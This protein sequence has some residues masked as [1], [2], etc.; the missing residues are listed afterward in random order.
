MNWS[1][2]IGFE[3]LYEVS[4]DGQVRSLTYPTSGGRRPR[5]SPLLIKQR[6]LRGDQYLSASL[7]DSAGKSH[8]KYVHSLVAEAFIGARPAGMDCRHADG[9][10]SNNALTNL[11]WRPESRLSESQ[12]RDIKKRSASGETMMR[13]SIDFGVSTSMISMIKNGQIIKWLGA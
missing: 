11:F 3:E 13:L 6:A 7:Y 8:T 9:D 4:D 10:R 2:V 5:I 1:A 12:V